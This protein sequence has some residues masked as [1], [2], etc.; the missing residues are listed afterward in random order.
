MKLLAI[1]EKRAIFLKGFK[2]W[3]IFPALPFWLRSGTIVVFLPFLSLLQQ[4]NN[5]SFSRR[6]MD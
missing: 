5:E 4:Q 3:P 6:T 2:H 1:F